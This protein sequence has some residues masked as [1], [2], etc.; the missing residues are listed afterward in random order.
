MET[1]RTGADPAF[2]NLLPSCSWINLPL[3]TSLTQTPAATSKF[4]IGRAL[5]PDG[6]RGFSSQDR[7]LKRSLEDQSD[8]TL[9]A[10]DEF[11]HRWAA[12]GRPSGPQNWIK[13]L[14]A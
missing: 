10:F 3:A 5:Q 12:E 11:L 14:Q 2:F 8:V 4:A 13:N 9:C 7:M 1:G 6:R